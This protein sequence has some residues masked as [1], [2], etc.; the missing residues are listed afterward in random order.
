MA[1][2][3]ERGEQATFALSQRL[4][5]HKVVASG[6]EYDRVVNLWDAGHAQHPRTVVLCE[7]A[8][9]V[10]ACVQ[11]AI[12]HNV[13]LSVRAGGHG[14]NGRSIRGDIVVDLGRMSMVQI[15][16]H[17]AVLSGAAMNQ[18]VADATSQH[19]LTASIGLVGT[20]GAIGLITGGGYGYTSGTSGLG[21]DNILAA[22]MV[23]ADGRIVDVDDTHE[24]DLFW[25]IRGG[26]GNFGVITKLR[27]RLWSIPDMSDGIIAFRWSTAA[28]VLDAFGR[29]VDLFADELTVMPFLI[30][31]P[32]GPLG[33]LLHHA[34]CGHGERDEEIVRKIQAFDSSN[35]SKIVNVGRKTLAEILTETERRLMSGKHWIVRQV[36]VETLCPEAT[37]IIQRALENRTSPLSWVA[38]HPF[39]GV[40]ERIPVTS[41]AFGIRQRH[42]MIGLYCAFEPGD[43]TPHREWVDSLETALQPFA[44]PSAYPNY[45]GDDRPAQAAVAYGPNLERLLQIKRR[46]DRKISSPPSQCLVKGRQDRRMKTPDNDRIRFLIPWRGPSLALHHKC[47]AWDKTFYRLVGTF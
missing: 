20:V 23:T 8:S 12:N 18:D 17:T 35:S 33:L 26:G 15:E 46:Y 2:L 19:G 4:D 7:T 16:G 42:L 21:S 36:T 24:P 32:N 40:A 27:I 11:A 47:I 45:I 9:D 29:A 30:S 38:A 5:G 10:Q 39:S 25:A 1:Q 14:P 3:H 28:D 41:T 13:S 37:R 34:F 6:P 44:L 22:E 31:P 43:D